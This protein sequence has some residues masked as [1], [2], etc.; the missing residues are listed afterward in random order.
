MERERYGEVRLR[1]DV[2]MDF[3]FELNGKV[4]HLASLVMYV[5]KS[6]RFTR[7]SSILECKI[8]TR[9]PGKKGV[10]V[11]TDEI[12]KK[13]GKG[14]DYINEYNIAKELEEIYG[15]IPSFDKMKE[16]QIPLPVRLFACSNHEISEEGIYSYSTMDGVEFFR[17]TGPEN[18]EDALRVKA[19]KKVS[20]DDKIEIIDD[21]VDPESGMPICFKFK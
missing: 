5:P 15:G 7:N 20:L 17:V 3:F 9:E 1:E 16:D 2:D 11:H 18:K 13:I 8:T 21:Q 19:T 4:V 12:T 6:L 10:V 14:Y